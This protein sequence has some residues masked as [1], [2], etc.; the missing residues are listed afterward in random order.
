MARRKVWEKQTVNE[1]LSGDDPEIKKDIKVCTIIENKGIIAYLSEKVSSW[2]KMK[3]IMAVALCY[4]RRLL[5]SVQEKK[6]INIDDRQTGLVSLEDIQ[7]AEKEIIK[8]V[9]EE[10]FKDEIEVTATGLEP[11][12][13]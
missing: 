2:S 9:Q 5:Q 10:Y 11:R 8:S 3:R 12:T 13:T 6:G 1:E 4:K 7:S